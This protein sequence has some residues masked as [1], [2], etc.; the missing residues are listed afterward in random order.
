M[1]LSVD[2]LNVIT[3][4][5][6]FVWNLDPRRWVF[7]KQIR[8][9]VSTVFKA[10]FSWGNIYDSTVFRMFCFR[11][12]K[13]LLRSVTSTVCKIRVSES[14]FLLFFTTK[15][16]LFSKQLFIMT[17][18]IYFFK[19]FF[20]GF[21]AFNIWNHVYLFEKEFLD[22]NKTLYTYY[23]VSTENSESI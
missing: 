20:V 6:A 14:I 18:P 3:F 17:L 23:I 16:I 12:C 7:Q 21:I 19:F 10:Q 8:F 5:F 13:K 11:F 22:S 9:D 2:V 1:L 4:L 15:Y